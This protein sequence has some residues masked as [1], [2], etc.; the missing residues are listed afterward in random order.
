MRTKADL[1]KKVDDDLLWRRRELFN[2]RT[3]IE[4]SEKNK[5]RQTAL[6]RAGVAVLY[7]HWEGFVKRAGSYYLEFVSNQRERAI[8]LTPNFVAIKFKARIIEAAKSKKIST[9]HD[10]IDFFC[11]HLEDRLKIP[12]KGI[13]DTQSNLSSVVLRDVIWTLGLD[14]SPY[15]TKSNFID[16]SLVDRRNHI[17]HGEPLDIGVK[18]YLALHDEVMTLLENFRNQIQNAAAT[19]RFLTKSHPIN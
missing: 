17:A 7:A 6:L 9:T 2:L 5:Q 10:V 19:D 3:A 14:F 18:D 8:A 4:D 11:N 12:H 16:A 15:E 1:Q 13:V